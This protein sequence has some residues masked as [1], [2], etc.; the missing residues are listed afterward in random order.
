MPVGDMER[1]LVIDAF[2]AIE[3]TARAYVIWD[4]VTADG[5]VRTTLDAA[6]S[7]ISYLGRA[8]SWCIVRVV[9]EAVVQK[10]AADE[11][12]RVV[13]LASRSNLNGPSSRRLG[14]AADYRGAGL[15]A[16]LSLPVDAMR[17][18]RR[19]VPSGAVWYEYRYPADF[20]LAPTVERRAASA[21]H[22]SVTESVGLRLAIEGWNE[23]R[24]PALTDA[25]IVAEAFRGA[26][27]RRYSDATG[28]G[29]PWQLSGKEHDRPLAGHR[30]AYFLPRDLDDDGRIDHIDVHFPSGASHETLVAVRRVAKLY[31]WRLGKDEHY[32]VTF[33][34][35][36]KLEQHAAWRTATPFLLGV[37]PATRG[38]TAR[39][40]SNGPEAQLRR[41]FA[42]RGLPE[43]QTVEFWP[44]PAALPHRRGGITVLAGFRTTRKRDH[45]IGTPLGATL[46][47]AKKV[48][49][50]LAVGRYAHF[51]MGQFVPDG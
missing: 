23:G 32:A 18:Q 50:P 13:D 21:R 7:G 24:G 51:G 45:M 43:P 3:R 17:Q 1:T 4:D 19:L 22:L 16:A 9:E 6:C 49:G 47:F 31:D 37:H 14:A 46:T 39:R 12:V 44:H 20:G 41:A 5:D 26:A 11:D 42:E 28:E 30:H 10:K 33:V 2:V 36:V 8:E 15:L 48:P 25:L 27:M 29:A 38:S 40:E 34:G 35:E